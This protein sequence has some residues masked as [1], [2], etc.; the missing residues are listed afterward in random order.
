MGWDRTGNWSERFQGAN[1]FFSFWKNTWEISLADKE[2][3][4]G[5][6]KWPFPSV[7]LSLSHRKWVAEKSELVVSGLKKREPKV[8]NSAD[9]LWEP[10]V[11]ILK[12]SDKRCS[13]K[14]SETLNLI[15]SFVSFTEGGWGI[16]RGYT[17]SRR[18]DTH[19]RKG[20]FPGCLSW[21]PL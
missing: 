18:K 14:E 1:L 12:D 3:T 7:S 16:R 9:E 17:G 10:T 6:L 4:D 15:A 21:K 5:S 20:M 2:I 19:L 8:L 11:G 13:S